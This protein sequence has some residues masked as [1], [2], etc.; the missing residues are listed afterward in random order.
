[1][2]PAS[3]AKTAAIRATLDAA[4]PETHNAHVAML[5][6]MLTSANKDEREQA[7]GIV[8]AYVAQ[9]ERIRINNETAAHLAEFANHAEPPD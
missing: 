4:G 8:R 7:K 1:M 2:T 9:A 3:A 5:L 6:A